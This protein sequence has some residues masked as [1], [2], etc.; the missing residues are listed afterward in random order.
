MLCGPH[1]ACTAGEFCSAGACLRVTA[2]AT[3]TYCTCAITSAGGVQCWGYNNDYQ[4]GNGTTASSDVPV[5]V[6]DVSSGVTALAVE[7]YEVCALTAGGVLQCWG[8]DYGG[9]PSAFSGF[10]SAVTAIS[11]GYNN[12]CAVTSAGAVQCWGYNHDGELGDGTTTNNDSPVSVTGITSGATAVACG[13]YHGCAVVGGS[14]QCWGLNN[15]GNLGNGAM[16]GSELTPVAVTSLTGVV[17]VTAG[18]GHTCALTSTGGAW[19]WGMN[20]YGEIGNNS[21]A[22]AL[23]PVAVQGLPSS[24]VAISAGAYHT[25]AVTSAGAVWCWGANDSGQLGNDT[26]TQSLLPVPVTNLSSGAVSVAAGEAHTC[27]TTSASGTLCWGYNPDG[28]LGNGTMT[29]TPS[30]V[31]TTVVEP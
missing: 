20:M 16:G 31:P 17:A 21:T 29:T 24:V 10:S 8:L 19:C 11:G 28:E 6:T 30:L 3:R 14:V 25:C 2:V 1:V 9:T 18:Y 12:S 23:V 4:L 13:T 7:E 15:W 22:N 27:A 26:M 5:A